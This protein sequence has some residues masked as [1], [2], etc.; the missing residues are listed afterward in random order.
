MVETL[1]I[2]VVTI[3]IPTW[4]AGL[5]LALRDRYFPPA[6]RPEPYGPSY[7]PKWA[8]QHPLI[9]KLV[10][11]ALSPGVLISLVPVVILLIPFVAWYYAA[12]AFRRLTY[13]RHPAERPA[14]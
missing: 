1:A 2:V 9:R 8:R 10:F 7:P 12:L 14:S 11:L 13:S 5:L 4:T 6:P 3:V